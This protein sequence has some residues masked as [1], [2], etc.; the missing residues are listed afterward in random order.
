MGTWSAL[1]ALAQSSSLRQST[2]TGDEG[3][4]RNGKT[5]QNERER[6]E[7]QFS[8]PGKAWQL[9]FFRLNAYSWQL[10]RLVRLRASDIAFQLRSPPSF[11][12]DV[13]GAF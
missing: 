9:G 2:E 11:V 5:T 3:G 10:L 1:L 12:L 4:Q 13:S 8:Q 6:E 7:E